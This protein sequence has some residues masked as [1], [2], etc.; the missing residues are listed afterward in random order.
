MGQRVVMRFGPLQVTL[1]QLQYVVALA[2]TKSFRKAAVLCAVS[3]PALSAQIAQVET[4]LKLTLFERD[5]R[6]VLL[7]AAGVA[8]VE[9]ARA[10]LS[11]ADALF[12][13]AQRATDPFAGSL[14]LGV[15]PTVGPYL[16][17]EITAPLR[18]KFPALRFTWSEGRTGELMADLREGRLDGALVAMEADLLPDAVSFV[19]GKDPFVL[20]TSKEH[21]LAKSTKPVDAIAL[22]NE[23]L[24]VL[25]EGHCLRN[26]VL[27]VCGRRTGADL[28]VRATSL[29]TL[30][31]MVVSGVG[32]TLLPTLSL[33]LENRLGTLHVRPFSPRVPER[34]LAMVWRKGTP[35]QPA[36]RGVGAV[37]R[38]HL[39]RAM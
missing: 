36:L 34:T 35:A 24:L 29:T 2:E 18:A 39:P 6:R 26:Q 13:E 12:D 32:V 21:A 23:E 7:T 15:I 38:D 27:D 22:E 33:R 30:S 19:V 3:Q 16:L 25:A 10:L 11:S 5:T 17:P 8:L 14:R 28:D 31:Q 4:A 9:R 20:V 1:R 37:I